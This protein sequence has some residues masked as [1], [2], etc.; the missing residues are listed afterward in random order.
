MPLYR[1]CFRGALGLESN[2]TGGNGVSL[3]FAALGAELPDVKGVLGLL[4]RLWAGRTRIN[5][6]HSRSKAG[7]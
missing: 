6:W 1:F 5:A 4:E 2:Q 7:R 3:V